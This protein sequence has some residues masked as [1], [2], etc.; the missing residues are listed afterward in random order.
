MYLERLEEHKTYVDKVCLYRI[1][2]VSLPP[3]ISGDKDVSA[4]VAVAQFVGKLS[5]N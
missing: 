3:P 5:R 1:F 2:W 4:L